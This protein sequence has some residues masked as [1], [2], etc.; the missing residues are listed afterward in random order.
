MTIQ[1]NHLDQLNAF[2]IRKKSEWGQIA[3]FW[4]WSQWRN[5]S[6]SL[7]MTVCV[8]VIDIKSLV[9]VPLSSEFAL[10]N[11]SINKTFVSWKFEVLDYSPVR[12]PYFFDFFFI[13]WIGSSFW[14]TRDWLFWM[15][16]F[17]IW[18]IAIWC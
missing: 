14:S 18:V 1:T 9:V 8:H 10:S 4:T 7:C 6:I 17:E 12:Y 11:F 3:V 13:F 15:L 2:F 16:T 5:T